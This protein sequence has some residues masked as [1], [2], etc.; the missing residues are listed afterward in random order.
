MEFFDTNVLV[1]AVDEKEPLRRRIAVALLED[2]LAK[3]SLVISTQVML[4]FRSEALKR[5][6]LTAPRITEFLREFGGDHIVPAREEM[7]WRTF[8]L[9]ERYGFSIWD[10]AIVQAALEARCDVLFTEDLQHG[11][12]I[13]SLQ[14]VNPFRGHAVHEPSP[15]YAAA[16]KPAAKKR[17]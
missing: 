10:A 3:G 9:Q 13:G 11:Q 2:S 5:R 14:V 15:A 17:R 8:D 7:V 12:Q 1:Y 16:R 6:H 4:E